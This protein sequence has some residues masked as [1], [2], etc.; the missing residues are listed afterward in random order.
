MMGSF[1]KLAKESPADDPEIEDL[2]QVKLCAK[3]LPAEMFHFSFS[4]FG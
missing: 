3:K 2:L 4:G 1:S